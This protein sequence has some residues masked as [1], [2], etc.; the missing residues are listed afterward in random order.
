[1]CEAL[2]ELFKDEIDEK[3]AAAEKRGT[4][5]T[6]YDLVK[7]NLITVKDAAEQ[8]GM[9]EASFASYMETRVF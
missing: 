5:D 6:L 2:M 9:S 4:M 1:M 3:E 7:K 8:A